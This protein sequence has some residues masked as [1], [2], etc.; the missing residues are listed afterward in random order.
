MATKNAYPIFMRLMN[1]LTDPKSPA[2]TGLNNRFSR[3]CG[4][5]LSEQERMSIRAQERVACFIRHL[6]GCSK[7]K[8]DRIGYD[9]CD[10][11]DDVFCNEHLHWAAHAG[12]PDVPLTLKLCATCRPAEKYWV[13]LIDARIRAEAKA[14]LSHRAKQGLKKKLGILDAAEAR[15]SRPF[16]FDRRGRARRDPKPVLFAGQR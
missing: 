11:C 15:F 9:Y 2:P 14:E 3:L 8:C 1:K 12:T 10:L 16:V 6:P 7:N 4:D 5:D 13:K